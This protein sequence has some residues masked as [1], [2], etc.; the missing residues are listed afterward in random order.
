MPLFSVI[1]PVYNAAAWVAR[2]LDS[3]LA[4][5]LR[6]MEVICIDDG[7]TDSS[8]GIIREYA[9]RDTRL[10]LISQANCG[11]VA[12]RKAG[13]GL[14]RG[15]FILFVDPD[16]WLE[17]DACEKILPVMRKRDCDILQFGVHIH[18]TASRTEAQKLK[19]ENYFNPPPV[20]LKDVKLL[21][22]CYLESKLSYNL[23]FRC[24]KGDL[25]R[26]AFSFMPQVFSVNETD[27]FSFFFISYFARSYA[28]I[29]DKYYHYSYGCGVSTKPR[30]GIEEYRRVLRKLDTLGAVEAFVSGEAKGDAVAAEC[31]KA[32]RG[33]MV[34]NS[35]SAA[36][37]RTAAGE[38]RK[39]AFAA[40]CAK[41]GDRELLEYLIS[42][43]KGNQAGCA[44]LLADLDAAAS[45]APSR[46]LRNVAI[47]YH[48]LTVGGVQ[49]IVRHAAAGL[50]ARGYGVVVVLEAK[51]DGE[52]A[53]AEYRLPGGVE[54]VR[55]PAFDDKAPSTLVA[56]TAALA[57]ILRE[58]NIDLFYSHAYSSRTFVYDLLLCKR[59]AKIPF[60]LHW[61]SAFAKSLYSFASPGRFVADVEFLRCCDCV[62]VLSR[63]DALFCSALG[64]RARY[65]PN[66]LVAPVQCG[67]GS[68][69]GK[70]LLWVG[71][72]SWEKRPLDAVEIFAAVHARMPD[73]RMTMVGGG[74]SAIADEVRLR[75]EELGL[76]DKV[77]L[78]GEDADVSRYYG[79]ASVLLVTSVFE[80][81]GLAVLEGLCHALPVVSYAIP[82]S[83]LYRGNEAVFQ[84]AQSDVA[85]AARAVESILA[86]DGYERISMAAKAFASKFS[87]YDF[88]AGLE[89]LLSNVSLGE[90]ANTDAAEYLSVENVSIMLAILVDGM[91]EME[92]RSAA[93]LRKA[94]GCAD[95]LRAK[96]AE[97]ES[98]L[99]A[100]IA[101]REAMLDKYRADAKKMKA[102][103]AA[104]QAAAA[105]AA[106][107]SS[108]PQ[109]E[110]PAPSPAVA[111]SS[112][113]P[114][115]L[116]KIAS[117]FFSSSKK[118]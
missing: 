83:E 57:A 16:D 65:L 93:Q 86:S 114:R 87:A 37:W 105:R 101:E 18:E 98:A 72:F 71:R 3:L 90:S 110:K 104:L 30:Y 75:V 113:A 10:H 42:T 51:A 55:L 35:C 81:F 61:H 99:R 32:L 1:V 45:A 54:I 73:C 106:A 24:F 88:L 31:F 111:R 89:A 21:P 66:P 40:L 64:A 46:P 41:I 118:G 43:F 2:C 59:I 82:Q 36:I 5:T 69:G 107:S 92:K 85:A 38:T 39:A 17:A 22:A 79:D 44:A 77:T 12:A 70:R 91:R 6:D 97:R 116:R 84:V 78:A 76:A 62:I 60:V 34:A 100:K 58:K 47:H 68:S 102:K 74:D 26:K 109:P 52:S 112:L 33:R 25:A 63:V 11:T 95:A 27:A 50:A 96:I 28:S 14:S 49:Q 48:H 20:E 117:L 19:S 13:V 7:S 94:N 103:I 115:A 67:A 15:E 8:S 9:R 23:I 56:R 4:Q 80:G 108:A 53:L 29:P